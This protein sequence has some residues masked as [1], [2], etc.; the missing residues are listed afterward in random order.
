MG[1]ASLVG[2]WKLV[3]FH[4]KDG[5][6]YPSYRFGPDVVGCYMFTESV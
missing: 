4:M 5:E 2:A 6:G 3:S 1:A